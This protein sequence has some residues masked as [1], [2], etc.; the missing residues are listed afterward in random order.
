MFPFLAVLVCTMGAL[1]V[2]LVV[3]IHQAQA[4]VAIEHSETVAEMAG[5]EG[6]LDAQAE[7]L[8]LRI[9]QLRAQRSM[10]ERDLAGERNQL[11]FIEKHL[12]ELKRQQRQLAEEARRLEGLEPSDRTAHDQKQRQLKAL[13]EAIARTQHELDQARHENQQPRSYAVVPYR[14][15][16]GT[17]RR[18][19]YIECRSDAI[20]LQPEGIVLT[21]DDFQT[22]Q[23]P[24]NPL[25]AALRATIEHLETQ[26]PA[27]AGSE[28][29][30]VRPYPLLLVRPDG[31]AA[32]YVA[33]ESIKS[34]ASDFG[35]E[36]VEADWDLEFPVPDP[37]LAQVQQR[38]VH[39][40]RQL[41][42]RILASV[43]RAEGQG[44]RPVFR[45]APGGGLIVE[46]GG[47][48]DGLGGQGGWGRGSGSSRDG[49]SGSTAGTT[50]SGRGYAGQGSLAPGDTSQYATGGAS[51]T[52]YPNGQLGASGAYGTGGSN[53]DSGRPSQSA[54][55]VAQ[56]RGANWALPQGH[57]GRDASPY[58]PKAIDRG[59]RV[60]VQEDALLV[61]DPRG[62]GAMKRIPLGQSTE[63]S[64]DEL[65]SAVWQSAGGW[66]PA[67]AG[68]YWQPVIEL[69]AL[70]SM[71]QRAGELHRLMADS[72]LEVRSQGASGQA[73]AE[74]T[75]QGNSA[76][77][78]SSSGNGSGNGSG[79][80][81][82]AENAAE[83]GP[84]LEA[85]A[86]MDA[87]SR[88][89]DSYTAHGQTGRYGDAAYGPGGTSPSQETANNPS[90][91]SGANP[92][93]FA[94]SQGNQP[95]GGATAGMSGSPSA[96]GS[97]AGGTTAS[98][99]S[100][101][102]GTNSAGSASQTAGGTP[103]GGQPPAMPP[104]ERLDP[105][106]LSRF[107][108]RG[109]Q[110]DS[111]T[112]ADAR[113][114]NWALPEASRSAIPLTRPIRV[115]CTDQELRVLSDDPRRPQTRSIALGLRTED[116]IDELVSVLWEELEHWGTAGRGMY[117]RPV[118][119]M[120][121]TPGGRARYAEIE[122]L[123]QNSGLELRSRFPQPTARGVG[124]PVRQ[125]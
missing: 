116:T 69:E 102:A 55:S 34:W 65:V 60:V 43:S 38:A 2:I 52:P 68:T 6:D 23:L 66:G 75:S 70:P 13:Q 17:E 4:E 123:L 47:D 121:V 46:E 48:D 76:G 114:R 84:R 3:I 36:L 115:I 16:H 54:P 72:G 50:V 11:A 18:P 122:S 110:Q 104:T 108:E 100:T 109:S 96:G 85:Q 56:R 7:L 1:I 113:G 57:P 28:E 125:R 40:A 14:G 63:A 92:G 83:G 90:G 37:Q 124:A 15:A 91:P 87:S 99:G 29:M 49:A 71:S 98:G 26:S 8:Q 88:G 119:V 82:L 73:L 86:G 111:K 101:A 67:E 39:E 64:V 105:Q 42:Q 27:G 31:V 19:V 95:S 118:L 93:N 25:A 81:P 41:Q 9:E 120:E 22:P 107:K 106:S 61:G 94:P 53:T 59:I 35:Y 89:S 58:A 21:E 80:Y 5:I 62:S 51:P 74:G 33:R 12:G 77:G 20:V 32:Y 78:H 112:L 97:S 30:K 24:G 10:T 117:W 44:S 103:T 45:A 79:R